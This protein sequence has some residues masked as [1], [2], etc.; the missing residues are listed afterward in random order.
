MTLKDLKIDSTW[1]L[2]L[3]R[4]GV[5]NKRIVG[6]YIRSWEQFIFLPGLPE[7]ISA[8]SKLFG[9]IIV[10]SNQQGI[11]KGLMTDEDVELIH[12]RMIEEIGSSG[13]RI[14]KAYHSPFLE[15]EKSI[16]RKPNVGMGLTARK[17][18]PDIRYKKSIMAGDS[19]SDMIFGRKLG[20][21]TVFLSDDKHIIHKGHPFIDFVFKDL[22]TFS[23][24]LTK[25]I[26]TK[27]VPH[28]H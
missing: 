5:I 10:V 16:H 14:N 13:G 1:T 19:L 25:S 26:N 23:T 6:D 28:V 11:G 15:Q 7:A 22:Y 20:M 21:K 27:N 9:K 8:L 2:F 12:Q 4:D 17:D 24:E 3:D 18:F